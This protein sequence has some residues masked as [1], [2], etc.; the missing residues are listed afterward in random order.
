MSGWL[1]LAVVG[2]KKQLILGPTKLANGVGQHFLK[3]SFFG[4]LKKKKKPTDFV[5]WP[6][7]F[8]G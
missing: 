2:P 8:V 5:G 3:K 4:R 6:K 7:I 1:G